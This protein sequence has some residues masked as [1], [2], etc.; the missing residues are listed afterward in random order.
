MTT[1]SSLQYSFYIHPVTH[2]FIQCTLLFY[3]AQ[4]GGSASCSRTLRHADF[5]GKTGD[6]TADL[7]CAFT[8]RA[9]KMSS[10]VVHFNIVPV[11]VYEA[12]ETLTT[13]GAG[14]GLVSQIMPH[15]ND[16]SHS[17]QYSEE[18]EDKKRQIDT[19]QCLFVFSHFGLL[20]FLKSLTLML[21]IVTTVLWY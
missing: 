18:S 10:E 8:Q 11:E 3:E 21:Y 2:T 17:T 16:L 14:T 15:G 12:F 7:Q 5:F 6:R 9:W 4:F 19:N 20:D 13:L 1:Q